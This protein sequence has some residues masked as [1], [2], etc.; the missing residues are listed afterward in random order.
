MN[1]LV[2]VIWNFCY[3]ATV[4]LI[5]LSLIFKKKLSMWYKTHF[6]YTYKNFL[7]DDLLDTD[8]LLKNVL[9]Y[10]RITYTDADFFQLLDSLNFFNKSLYLGKAVDFTQ[11]TIIMGC[12]WQITQVKFL[13]LITIFSNFLKVASQQVANYPEVADIHILKYLDFLSFKNYGFNFTYEM[14]NSLK[15]KFYIKDELF[16]HYKLKTQTYEFLKS[17]EGFVDQ[18]DTNQKLK[19]ANIT[20]SDDFIK[21]SKSKKYCNSV[22]ANTHN[23]N[24][25]F[26]NSVSSEKLLNWNSMFFL[27]SVFITLAFSSLSLTDYSLLK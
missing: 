21:R 6:D 13:F 5:K 24:F 15:P 1:I 17:V 9:D 7:E 19:E 4:F 8:L 20:L 10:H 11:N 12:D 18:Q 16:C 22:L 26:Q 23:Y 2:N 3:Y 14:I 27:G 25:Y